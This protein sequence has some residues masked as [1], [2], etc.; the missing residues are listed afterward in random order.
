MKHII[1]FFSF[2]TIVTITIAQPG[3]KLKI[4]DYDEKFDLAEDY[5]ED[6][7]FAEA[8]I[9]Y[10]ELLTENPNDDA[11]NF[12]LG[13][14]Y[15]F[16]T[17]KW[18]SI[19]PFE[20]VVN[21]YRNSEPKPKNAPIDAYYGL[22]HSLY[23]NYDFYGA[24][25]TYEELL[26]LVKNKGDKIQIKEKIEICDNAI[27]IFENPKMMMVVKLGVINSEYA[28]HS[29]TVSADES[30]VIFTSR[31]KG[32]T[33]G[34]V[35]DDN[36]FYEDIYVYDKRLGI[37]AKPKKIDTLVNSIYHEA[38]SGLS[39]DGKELFLYKSSNKDNGD[40]YYCS[41]E[42]NKWSAPTELKGDVNTKKRESHASI[43][44]DGKHL[45]F[46]SSRKGGYGGL[47]IYV[48]EKN[49]EGEW[50]NVKNLGPNINTELDEE[51]PFLNFD[52]NMLYFSSQG[53]KPMGGFDIFYSKLDESGNWAK[54]VNMG[55][56][57][58]TVDNDVFF[59]PTLQGNRAY[60]S[61]QQEGEFSNI[62]IV[63][64][65]ENENNI[66][67]V[68]GFTYDSNIKNFEIPKDEVS[69]IGDT[70]VIGT[71]KVVGNKMIDY[72]YKDS[73]LITDKKI[74]DNR[75]FLT[76]SLCKIPAGTTIANYFVDTKILDNFY[77]PDEENGKYMFVIR[78]QKNHLIHYEAPGHMFDIKNIPARNNGF[79]N[80]FYKAELDTLIIGE[81]KQTRTTCFDLESNEL[82][83]KQ[84]LEL[85]LIAS[86]MKK[87]DYLY[88][89]FSSQS[90]MQQSS[91]DGEAKIT[92]AQDYLLANG[93]SQDRILSDLSINSIN[94]GCLEYTFFDET[95]KIIAENEKEDKLKE[96]DVVTEQQFVVF[97]SNVVFEINKHKTDAYNADLDVLAL[98][99]KENKDAKISISGYTDTQGPAWY[100]KKLA[101]NR[102][103]F[104]KD[105]LI[106]KGVA[107]NQIQAKGKGFDK[108]I[109]KNTDKSGNFILDA[110]GY[111]RRV[112]IVVT[113]QGVNEKLKVKQIEVPSQ[114]SV[115]DKTV[116]TTYSISLFQSKTRKN[117]SELEE[118]V[119]ELSKGD[120]SM[121]YYIIGEY[122]THN[123]AKIKLVEMKT[124]YSNAFIYKN[125]K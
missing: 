96:P 82:S 111:N 63:E 36:Q 83:I 60:Y 67:L 66:I 79:S 10:N 117:L 70:A 37:D 118:G 94:P 55:F 109:A 38:T 98:F 21:N 46:T 88:V 56:P 28:D 72:H 112:E 25:Q 93:I 16:M 84:E 102:A 52:G 106:A 120:E 116:T 18:M 53:H 14:C 43:S 97:V 105:Y 104:V 110:L 35:A 86:F 74:K 7:K 95:T 119:K 114:Y 87:N 48:A 42:N 68:S 47:D 49:T 11:I 100:N 31:R 78:P 75:V 32:S 34:K 124:K 44:A 57:L 4:A 15:L 69:M 64:F 73:I 13:F 61:S 59:A 20:K 19:E 54:P 6:G 115:E 107:E 103:N 125:S 17:K 101:T 85:E 12:R 23:I 89:S 65:Y 108:Q 58:N 29:P 1:L 91:A 76:D 45:Y 80:V 62:Y 5:I 121:Y 77:N 41:Y 3:D 71:R 51:G 123:E 33:G 2:F 50:V 81:I 113:Q 9:I 39:F 90:Y 99:M 30:V 122:K 40:I 27:V 8:I 92:T 26:G 22:A 24:K